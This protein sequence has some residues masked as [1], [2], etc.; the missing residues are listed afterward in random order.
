MEREGEN[1]GF[2]DKEDMSEGGGGCSLVL[3]P[4]LLL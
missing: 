2:V 3:M 4:V 1:R